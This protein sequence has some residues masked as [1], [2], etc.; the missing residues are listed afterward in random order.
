[1]QTLYQYI[2]SHFN[3]SA[4]AD[5]LYIHRTTFFYRWNRILDLTSPG[6]DDPRKLLEIMMYFAGKNYFGNT[7]GSPSETEEQKDFIISDNS[8]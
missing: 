1:M 2:A 8:V 3:A 5:A 7:S 6:L 4:A